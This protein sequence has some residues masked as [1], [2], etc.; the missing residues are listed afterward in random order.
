MTPNIIL[1]DIDNTLADMDHRIHYVQRDPIDYEEFE[2]QAAYDQPIW[3]TIMT[4]QAYKKAG[5]QVWVWSGR[6]TNIYDLTAKWL[7]DNNVPYDQLLLRSPEVAEREPAELTKLN[8]LLHGPVPA[9]R[10]TCAFDDD[11][12]VVRVLRTKG[13]IQVFH[14][15]RPT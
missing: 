5:K 4:A 11:R 3:P 9:D 1:F 10:V 14:V 2:A 15:K 6:T 7:V 12:N 8:W 13:G